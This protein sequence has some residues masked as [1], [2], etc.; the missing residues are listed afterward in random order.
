MALTAA[1]YKSNFDSRQTSAK[2]ALNMSPDQGVGNAQIAATYGYLYIEQ[3]RFNN[4]G[5]TPSATAEG[6]RTLAESALTSAIGKLG[7]SPAQ[8]VAYCQIASN[9]AYLFV[10]QVRVEQPVVP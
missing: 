1:Q 9:Y 8:C 5:I 4:E 7:T 3:T 6:Y 2:S 10:E